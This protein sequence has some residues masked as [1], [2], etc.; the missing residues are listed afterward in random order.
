[1]MTLEQKIKQNEIFFSNVIL[2]LKENGIYGFPDAGSVFIKKDGK[3][4]G[5]PKDLDTVKHLVSPEFF[6]RY[7]TTHNNE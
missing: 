2:T 1:M 7:F 5:T 3:L 6:L 4:S